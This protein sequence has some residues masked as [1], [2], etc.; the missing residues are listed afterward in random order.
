MLF[1]HMNLIFVITK[2]SLVFWDLG[3]GHGGRV[4]TL[5]PPTSEAGVWVGKLV[6]SCHWSAVYSTQ[7]PRETVCTGILC[8]SNY[9]S[10]YDLYSVESDIKHQI[11]KLGSWGLLEKESLVVIIFTPR[12]PLASSW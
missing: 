8:P 2:L 1:L 11:N 4:V 5:S 12:F 10:L 9:P 3:G 6:V 7:N